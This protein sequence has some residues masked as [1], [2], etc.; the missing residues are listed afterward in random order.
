MP[1]KTAEG[2]LLRRHGDVEGQ[3]ITAA[4]VV[5]L[6]VEIVALPRP[7]LVLAEVLHRQ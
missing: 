6:Q 3:E 4:G 5:T 1:E 2:S 7:R